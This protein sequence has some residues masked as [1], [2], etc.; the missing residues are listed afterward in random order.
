MGL[1][2]KIAQAFGVGGGDASTASVAAPASSTAETAPSPAPNAPS[3]SEA[4]D[5]GMRPHDGA[6]HGVSVN[7][8]YRGTGTPFEDEFTDVQS[9]TV[10]LIMEALGQVGKADAV[11]AAYFYGFLG[12]GADQKPAFSG[13]CRVGDEFIDLPDLLGGDLFLRVFSIAC[14][15]L[16]K[17]RALCVQYGQPC[18]SEIRARYDARGDGYQAGYSYDQVGRTDP[19]DDTPLIKR[20]YAWMDAVEAG[21]DDLA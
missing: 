5:P 6:F 15:D 10:A 7:E 13:F 8:D 19:A 18:P 12:S 21:Q 20:F 1:F 3:A 9:D 2:D 14:D 11:D 16:R 17:L 4:P